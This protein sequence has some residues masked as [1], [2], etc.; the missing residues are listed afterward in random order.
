MSGPGARG[1]SGGPTRR[2]RL[3]PLEL[4]GFAAAIGVFAGLIALFATHD[5]RLAVIFGG[6]GFIA[7]LLLLAMLALATGAPDEPGP[8]GETVLDRG[9]RRRAGKQKRKR[10]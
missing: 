8:E 5:G 7:G 1:G 4:V 2:D 3:K 6:I 10:R 9:D